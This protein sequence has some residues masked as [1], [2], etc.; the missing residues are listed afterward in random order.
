M[1]NYPCEWDGCTTPAEHMIENSEFP[2]G[3][4]LCGRH[5]DMWIDA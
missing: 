4:L 5:Y 1:G 3:F 2:R